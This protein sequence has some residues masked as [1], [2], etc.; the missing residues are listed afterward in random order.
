MKYIK[1]DIAD[2]DF[3]FLFWNGIVVLYSTKK[4]AC[5]TPRLNLPICLNSV[6]S[7]D[8]KLMEWSKKMESCNC[9]A[10][11]ASGL[12]SKSLYFAPL[13]SSRYIVLFSLSAIFCWDSARCNPNTNV[14][15]P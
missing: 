7:L 3:L 9:R 14:S 2:N 8:A 4:P 1:L 15:V 12:M 10:I 6:C 5:F 11:I 13:S